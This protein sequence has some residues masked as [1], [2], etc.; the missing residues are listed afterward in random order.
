MQ[1]LAKD[2]CSSAQNQNWSMDG[3]TG[4]EARGDQC[5]PFIPKLNFCFDLGGTG[6][7]E[8]NCIV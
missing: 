7:E 3:I 6:K 8:N 5:E 4:G 2:N 1:F